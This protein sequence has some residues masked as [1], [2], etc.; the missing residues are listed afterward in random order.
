MGCLGQFLNDC[1]CQLCQKI[2]PDCYNHCGQ[3]NYKRGQTEK[4]LSS[5]AQDCPNRKRCLNEY[6]EYFGCM[7]SGG[8]HYPSM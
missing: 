8:R 3:H 2:D 1:T 4:Y 6:D 5:I 7:K